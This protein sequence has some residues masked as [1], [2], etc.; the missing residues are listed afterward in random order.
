[1]NQKPL[2]TFMQIMKLNLGFL[3]IQYSFGLQQS[4]VNPIYS[5]LGADPSQIPLLNLAGP[6]TGLIIQPIIGSMSDNTWHGRWGRRKPYFFIGAIL[7]S[8]ALFIYPF[9]SSLWMAVGMLW[10]LDVANNTAMEPYK[11]F[12]A[13]YLDN[14][15]QPTGFLAQS[16]FA[17][18]GISLAGVSLTLF[19]ALDASHIQ[20]QGSIPRWVYGSFF[21]GAVISISSVWFSI[22]DV[23]EFPPTAEEAEK[24]KSYKFNFADTFRD[25]LSAIKSMPRPMWL[26]AII[27]LFQWYALFC[28]WQFNALSVAQSVFGTEDVHTL[29]YNQAVA[30]SGTMNAIYNA[31]TFIV[32]FGLLYLVKKI[33]AEWV[34]MFAL[35]IGGIGL[36]CLPSI[37]SKS[38]TILPMI[39][40]GITWASIM[41]VPYIFIV[42]YL[43]KNQY[44]VYMGIINMMIVI[45]MLIQTITFGYIF[46]HYLGN[47]AQNAIVLAGIFLC[48]AG[49][50][51]AIFFRKENKIA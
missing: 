9:S 16:F 28:Y 17:G 51:T 38:M 34:H 41:G 50:L 45:P 22:R 46:K 12:V 21:I 15:Q 2:H 19:Q 14:S 43:P 6:M 33:R 27:Y 18:L 7:C 5:Y 39:A 11:A 37:Q 26:L 48:I 4:A 36:I 30:W 20:T 25:I 47:S 29:A 1:M 44:G 13:D 24:I 49:L 10:I 8:L 42:K 3:G 31:V 40:L 23:K 32:A 35:I